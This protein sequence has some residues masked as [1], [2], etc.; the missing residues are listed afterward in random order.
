[1]SINKISKILILMLTVLLFQSQFQNL[2]ADDSQS[3]DDEELPAIDPFQGGTGST[4]GQAQT[5]QSEVS[6]SVGLLNN[7]RLVGVIIARTKKIAILSSP[8]GSAFKYEINENITENTKLIEINSEYIVV[9]DSE[10]KFYEVYMNNII[11]ES[12]G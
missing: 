6:Q 12:N 7:Q 4:S 11:K 3:L 5:G 2:Y 10:N 8:D 9:E 1:M